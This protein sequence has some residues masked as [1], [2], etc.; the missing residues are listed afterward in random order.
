MAVACRQIAQTQRKRLADP[1]ERERISK[2]LLNRRKTCSY[3]GQEGH[4]RKGCPKLHG[5]IGTKPV[6]EA[7]P[8]TEAHRRSAG[9]SAVFLKCCSEL[10]AQQHA[11]ARMSCMWL[12]AAHAAI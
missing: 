4:N 3:C 10:C 2:A 7:R 9:L 8:I 6:A 5:K 11:G 1:E 12:R